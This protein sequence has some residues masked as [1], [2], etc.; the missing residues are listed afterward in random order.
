MWNVF[1]MHEKRAVWR[2]GCS[3]FERKTDVPAAQAHDVIYICFPFFRFRFFF[4]RFARSPSFFGAH[5]TQSFVRSSFLLLQRAVSRFYFFKLLIWNILLLYFASFAS[6]VA[7]RIH[8]VART[9]KCVQENSF[10]KIAGRQWLHMFWIHHKRF[11]V[12]ECTRARD[13]EK[14]TKKRK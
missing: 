9:T 4:S 1:W 11:S 3:H 8:S 2:R 10:P 14:G 5:C 13:W 6:F 12:S 7:F